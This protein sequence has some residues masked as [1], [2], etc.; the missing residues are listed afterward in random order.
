MTIEARD[1]AHE[2]RLLK[3]RAG[4]SLEHGQ[5]GHGPDVAEEAV[6][7]VRRS[8]RLPPDTSTT[9]ACTQNAQ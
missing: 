2:Y 7:V 5:P 6:K 1:P 4:R 9:S 3:S 8:E